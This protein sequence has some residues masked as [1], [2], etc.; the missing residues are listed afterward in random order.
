MKRLP[1]CLYIKKKKNE[2]APKTFP[3]MGEMYAPAAPFIQL[4]FQN[5]Y[6]IYRSGRPKALNKI[7][8]HNRPFFQLLQ[9]QGAYSQ[10]IVLV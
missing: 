1:K 10:N 2:E 9:L 5:L 7:H 6:M 4:F 8:L 3:S